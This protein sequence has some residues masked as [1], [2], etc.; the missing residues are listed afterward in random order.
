VHEPFGEGEHLGSEQD[1][2]RGRHLLHAGSQVRGLP[3]GGVVHAEVRPDGAN[4]DLARVQTD[5]DL[6]GDALGS[7]QFLGAPLHGVLHA[8]RCVTSPNRMVL[9]RDGRTE[10]RHDAIAHHLVDGALVAMDGLHHAFEDGIENF[11]SFLGIA[12]SEQLHRALQIGEEDGDL[13]ALALEGGLRREDLRGEM[14]GGV[15]LGAGEAAHCLGGLAA[16]WSTALV[17][18]PG[19]DRQVTT[20]RRAG[21]AKASSTAQAEVRP[22]WV[23]VLAPRTLQFRASS[24]PGWFTAPGGVR[25]D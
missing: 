8:E 5:P 19:A 10:E 2:T 6:D 11:A 13:L 16:Y 20:A 17:A 24:E 25:R 1:R 9:L 7:P 23:L 15:R 14:L 21:R 22:E 12:V 4:D 18:E 3:H